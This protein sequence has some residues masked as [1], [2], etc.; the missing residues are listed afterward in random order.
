[1][2]AAGGEYSG[3]GRRTFTVVGIQ[4][5]QVEGYSGNIEDM[6]VAAEVRW[7]CRGYNGVVEVE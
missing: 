4:W 5:Q 6:I 2:I 1:M 7:Q 3:D